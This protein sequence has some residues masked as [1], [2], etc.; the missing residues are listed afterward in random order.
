MGAD[1]KVLAC[2]CAI[3]EHHD[4]EWFVRPF[5]L[6]QWLLDIIEAKFAIQVM[7]HTILSH[8]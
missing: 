5:S 3:E 6:Q 4:L 7:L 2:G 1:A 8:I